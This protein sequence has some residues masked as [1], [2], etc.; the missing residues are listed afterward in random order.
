MLVLLSAGLIPVPA[1]YAGTRRAESW[2]INNRVK[3]DVQMDF[4]PV[5]GVLGVFLFILG[6]LLVATRPAPGT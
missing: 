5:L 4:V 3:G 6:F 2:V 1:R